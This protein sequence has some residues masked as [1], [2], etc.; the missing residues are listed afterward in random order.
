MID[1]HDCILED[2]I[3]MEDCSPSQLIEYSFNGIDYYLSFM[4]NHH[5]YIIKNK[6]IKVG[7]KE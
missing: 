1:I 2:T 4:T 5:Y 6:N 7:K 3:S